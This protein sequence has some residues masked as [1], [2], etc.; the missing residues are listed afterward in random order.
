QGKADGLTSL[1]DRYP[2]RAVRA[3]DAI[4]QNRQL[5]EDVVQT[6]FL[7]LFLTLHTFDRRRPFCPWFYRSVVNAAVKASRKDQRTVSL[8]TPLDT[9]SGDT[10][11]ELLPDLAELPDADAIRYDDMM[12]DCRRSYVPEIMWMYGG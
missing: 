5:A 1:V 6:A 12:K 11:A 8:N 2:E 3:A 10:F 7:R 4:T 9:T